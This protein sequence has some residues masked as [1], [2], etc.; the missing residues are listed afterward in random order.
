MCGIT[1][2]INLSR[3]KNA[4]A[5]LIKEMTDCISY[6]GPDG[7]GFYVKDNIALGHRRLGILDLSTGSQP[8]YNS[9]QTKV[10]VFNG[11][12]YNYIELRTELKNAGLTF[13]TNS[14]TEV[15]LN[16]FEYWGYDCMNKFNG[17]WA[18]AIWDIHSQELLISRDRIGEKPLNYCFTNDTLIFGSEIKSIFKY[19]IKKEIRPELIEI[20][21]T[22]SNIPAPDTFFKNIYKLMPGHYMILK[23]G[24]LSHHKYWDIPDIDERNMA[25]D[26][27]SVYEKFT[28]LLTDSVK[29]RM[30]SDVPFGAFLSGGLDSSSIVALM[31]DL[32]D[33]QIKT[34]NIGFDDKT[35][36]E[37]LLSQEVSTAFNTKHYRKT[38]LPD[39][40]D[41]ILNQ[42]IKH[43]DEPFGDPSAIPTGV[44]SK[45]AS[46]Q[47]KMVLTG[48]GGDELLS[49]YT[50]FQGIKLAGMINSMPRFVRE[51][52]PILSNTIANAT[53]G[54]LRYKL[55][56]VSKIVTTAGLDFSYKITSKKAPIDFQI[57][58]RL[59][60]NLE[61]TL[62]AESYLKNILSK[63]TY[64]DDFYKLMYLNFKHDLPNDYLVKVDRMSM[65]HSLEARLPFLDHRLIEFMCTV[66]KD[67]KM[68]GWERKSVLRKTI[69]KKLPNSILKA[70]KKGFGIPLREW[71]KKND[72]EDY[73]IN[74]TSKVSLLLGKSE[75]EDILH[76]NKVGNKDNGYFIWNLLVL[77]KHLS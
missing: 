59:T 62:P 31:S 20:F 14:D 25:S 36:D 27:S 21:L 61:N 57:L 76:Q 55:N 35:Y 69:G 53:K 71:F 16:A 28:Y 63:C 19:G 26:K 1:G 68:Q 38:V 23:N 52:L 18:F 67:V 12:I 46:E 17:M 58:K 56:K 48:D 32:S 30:R 74:N 11:E 13:L 65:A 75:I 66:H 39:N 5:R 50:S 44:V 64:K 73:L 2:Y 54:K 60:A 22:Y 47:V 10:I 8:M 51:G 42:I 40:I 45:F 37:T 33:Y 6:R 3:S 43:Y 70:P 4:D 41:N 72:F 9:D 77:N 24:D 7:Q 34:F 29:I 15:V 49:G